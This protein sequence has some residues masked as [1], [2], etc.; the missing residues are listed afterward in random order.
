MEGL[1]NEPASRFS[2][3]EHLIKVSM[4]IIVTIF[5]RGPHAYMHAHTCGVVS[6]KSLYEVQAPIP[7]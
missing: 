6:V 3:A 1:C 2:L 4:E 5:V 7:N